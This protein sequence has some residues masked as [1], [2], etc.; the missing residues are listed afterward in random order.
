MIYPIRI[1]IIA[2][3]TCIVSFSIAQDPGPKSKSGAVQKTESKP[4]RILTNGRRISIQSNKDINKIIVWTASGN[5][6]V[7]QT[8]LETPSYNFT[9]PPKEKYVFMMLELQGVRRYTEKIGVQ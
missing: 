6:F 8:N 9:I 3:F 5:R 7:E 1:G 4:F 2:V